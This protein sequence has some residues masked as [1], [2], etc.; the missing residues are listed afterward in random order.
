MLRS[1]SDLFSIRFHKLKRHQ[2]HIYKVL[3]PPITLKCLAHKSL[4]ASRDTILST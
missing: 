1:A 4:L 3:C 2:F